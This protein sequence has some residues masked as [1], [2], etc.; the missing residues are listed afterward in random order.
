MAYGNLVGPRDDASRIRKGLNSVRRHRS[1]QDRQSEVTARSEPCY[2]PGC[3]P[4]LACV[5]EWYGGPYDPDDMDRLR[6]GFRVGRIAV[7][8]SKNPDGP[9]LAIEPTAWQAFAGAIKAGQYDL[10]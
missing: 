10:I 3:A 6:C 5:L 4:A 8:D 1:N 7:R 9:M 2:T